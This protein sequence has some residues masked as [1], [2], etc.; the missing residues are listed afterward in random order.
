MLVGHVRVSSNGHRQT[1]ALQ[2]YAVLVAGV[3]DRHR[4]GTAIVTR[5]GQ[6]R[7]FHLAW[8]A[9]SPL[10]EP[11]IASWLD[12]GSAG[13]ILAV[14]AERSHQPACARRRLSAA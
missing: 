12:A 11:V 1:T 6:R 4:Y 8:P 9:P 13:P 2:R 14:P 10:P 7:P 3:D 5:T